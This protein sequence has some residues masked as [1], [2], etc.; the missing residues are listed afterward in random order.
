MTFVLVG[1]ERPA[2]GVRSVGR[3]L[4]ILAMFIGDR[5]AITVRET[6]WAQAP[7]HFGT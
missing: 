4:D 6:A 3:A 7:V 2:G 1:G 5:P